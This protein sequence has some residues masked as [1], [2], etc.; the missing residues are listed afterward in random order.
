MDVDMTYM[1]QLSTG[2]IMILIVC[3]TVAVAVEQ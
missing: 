1:L 2:S 3:G